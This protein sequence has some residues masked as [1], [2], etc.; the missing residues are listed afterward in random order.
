M[1]YSEILSA[2]QSL[3]EAERHSLVKALDSENQCEARVP[4]SSR[5]SALLEKQG[6]CPHCGGSHYYRFGKDHGTQRF[7]CKDCGRTFT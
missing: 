3:S 7:K 6:R 2:A 5:L 4:A 1:T